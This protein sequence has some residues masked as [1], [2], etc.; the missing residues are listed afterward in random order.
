MWSVPREWSADG[1]EARPRKG[2]S[3]QPITQNSP[4]VGFEPFVGKHWGHKGGKGSI[5]TL[6][7][8]LVALS[9]ST[10]QCGVI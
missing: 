10:M 7:V 8:F 4:G 6:E 2:C 1:H 3:S 9:V 5:L